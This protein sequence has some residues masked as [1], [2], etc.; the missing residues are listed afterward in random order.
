[1]A[2]HP[3]TKYKGGW[4][5]KLLVKY[6]RPYVKKMSFGLSIKTIGT[7][8]DL[9]L[10]W[11]LSHIIDNVIPKEN[12]VE[13]F[14][15]GG[16]MIICSIIAA[17]FN[18]RANRMASA[19]SCNC[20][21]NVRYD[22]YAKI[23]YLDAAQVD[24]F[25]ISSLESRL[26][27]D[28]YNLNQM[29][30]MIQ[31]M[32][33]RAP[34][35]L[36]GGITV[37]FLLDVRLTLVML[38]TLPFIALTVTIISKKSIPLYT[39]LQQAIDRITRVVR[40]NTSG[41]RIIKALG[42]SE[43]EKERFD[44]VNRDAIDRE[45][46]AGLTMAASNPLITFILNAGLTAVIVVGAHLVFGGLSSN[47]KIIAFMSYFT[48]ISNALLAVSRMFTLISKGMASVGRISAVLDE[49]PTLW[50]DEDDTHTV[51]PDPNA[52]QI[53]FRNVSFSFSG[54]PVLQNISF[55]LEKGQT[56]GLI[57]ATG[58]GKSTLIALLLRIYAP[59][60]GEIL[61]DGQPIGEIPTES[62]RSRFGVVFQNDFLFADTIRENVN[63]G[64]TLTDDQISAALAD[65]QAA[66]F[67]SAYPDKDAHPLDIKGANLSGGQK[68][69]L[70]VARAL[71]GD[72][73]ILILDDSSSALDYKTDAT[74]RSTITK[75][76][77]SSTTL[78]VAQRV[79]SIA[80]AHTII[81]L[82][83]GKIIGMGTHAELLKNCTPYREIAETQMGGGMLLD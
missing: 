38:C 55:K 25:T 61:I 39:Q 53:E 54:A 65:A 43:Y 77:N 40:E 37:T 15:W 32:G 16:I 42:K 2:S 56:L 7:L 29:T 70:L 17:T 20:T 75:K 12:K 26:T 9:F 63:F 19:V 14:F 34:I 51:S 82:D 49:D 58:S 5:L 27:G 41:V 47:G 28:T 62:L 71:A 83:A 21:Q 72:P 33:I 52:P 10:P 3:Q 23:S 4:N 69:R 13:I 8:M 35:L 1:M 59:D 81:M 45:K 67:V 79:S 76:Y 46:K 78:L 57:G 36:L 64:R 44:V 74:L 66:E 60:S 18:I 80:H 48:I 24:R 73:D 6:L 31:R 68:Q 30:G 11:I 50:V 22:L